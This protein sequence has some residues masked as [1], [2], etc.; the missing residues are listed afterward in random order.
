M[1]LRTLFQVQDCLPEQM[2][3]AEVCGVEAQR[4]RY[5]HVID[6]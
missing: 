3:P 2:Q 4:D 1:R 6:A 5:P